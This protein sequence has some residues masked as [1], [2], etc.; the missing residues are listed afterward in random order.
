MINKKMK[1]MRKF[2]MLMKIFM[3]FGIKNIKKIVLLIVS[4]CNINL[5]ILLNYR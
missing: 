4:Q 2:I 5:L 3:E 1:K